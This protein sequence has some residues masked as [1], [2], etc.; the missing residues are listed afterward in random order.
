M[1]V[2]LH[3]ERLVLDELP[4]APGAAPW[5]R[6]AVE[7]ELT[8]LI[9]AGGPAP[10][11]ASLGAVPAL[12]GGSIEVAPEAAPAELGAKIAQAVYGGLGW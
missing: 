1:N 5:V 10:G 3:V 7:A 12:T 8:R 9:A 11:L 6:A 2:R 4:L